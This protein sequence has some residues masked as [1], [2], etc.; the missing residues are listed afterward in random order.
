MQIITITGNLG[1]DPKFATTRDSQDVCNLSLGV[2]QGWG[3]RE[4]TNW[5]R[6]AVWG[7]RAKHVADNLRKGMKA[8]V[9]GEFTLGE[10]EGK[11][12][13]EVRATDIDW[14]KVNHRDDGNGGHAQRQANQPVGDG[15]DD[16]GS[17]V[18]F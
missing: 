5:Y 6:V 11:P 7:K 14:H 18:P 10:Y 16:D 3:D 15:W 9:V 2:R 1:Q 17:E 8:T 4:K 13:L 12:Q